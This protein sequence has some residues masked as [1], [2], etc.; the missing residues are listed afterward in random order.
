[1]IGFPTPAEFKE[2]GKM[3][4]PFSDAMKTKVDELEA[5]TGIPINCPWP[6]VLSKSK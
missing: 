1:M 2:W 4:L 5:L 3:D 6:T